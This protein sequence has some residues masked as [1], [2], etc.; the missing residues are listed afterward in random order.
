MNQSPWF[1]PVKKVRQLLR[2][3]ENR[4]TETVQY[5]QGRAKNTGSGKVLGQSQKMKTHRSDNKILKIATGRL[6]MSNWIISSGL[7]DG[8]VVLQRV[9]VQDSGIQECAQ[10]RREGHSALRTGMEPGGHGPGEHKE[11]VTSICLGFVRLRP[12]LY[13]CWNAF[14]KWCHVPCTTVWQ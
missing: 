1:W 14:F 8:N 13:F 7:K 5:V 9:Q 12:W 11:C 2:T 6:E 4:R 3:W 10:V